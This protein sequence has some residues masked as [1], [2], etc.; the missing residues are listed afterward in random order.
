V[1]TLEMTLKI[2]AQGFVLHPGSYLRSAWN[3]VDAVIVLSALISVASNDDSLTIMRA[4]R[5]LRTLRPLRMISRLRGLQ[6]V[7]TALIRSLPAV[8]NVV[9]FGV[10][11]VG[12]FGI[13]GV[14]LFGGKFYSCNDTNVRLRGECIGTF[15]CDQTSIEC[16]IGT[17][18]TRLW[19]NAYLN[20]DN[21]GE[22]AK[23]LFVVATLDDWMRVTYLCMDAVDVDVQPRENNNP[24]MA[25]YVLGFVLLGSFFWINLLVGVIIDNYT[26]LVAELGEAGILTGEQQ[27]WMHALQLKEIQGL[28]QD[29]RNAPENPLR[30]F[31]FMTIAQTKFELFITSCIL[32]NVLIMATETGSQSEGYFEFVQGANKAFTS[33][34][35]L[36][37]LMKVTALSP[38][39]YI[40]DGWNLFDF[41]IVVVSL[42]DLF[43]S[44]N[45]FQG[46]TVFRIFRVGRLFKLIAGA[47]GLRTLFNT[48]L[49]S[50]PAI[51]NVG[52]LLF[53]LMFVYGVM[54]MNMF[55]TNTNFETHANFRDFGMS[56]LTLFRV[57]TGDSWSGVLAAAQNCDGHGGCDKSPW[58]SIYFLSFTVIGS[59][60][61]LNLIIAVIL[62]QFITAASSEGLLRTDNFFDVLS[63]KVILDRFLW[64]LK[65]KLKALANGADIKEMQERAAKKKQELVD[66]DILLGEKFGEMY[67]SVN[68]KKKSE[69]RKSKKAENG[70]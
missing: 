46:A 54:G 11:E 12:V 2:V 37:A 56:L 21:I 55:G 3:V 63:K 20:F 38:V 27:K 49:S 34:F 69:R 60:V 29:M 10:F 41:V 57:F 58:P 35:L 31:I 52:G 19:E 32:L 51:F 68:S 61:M 43:L 8:L 9:L 7:V 16:E 65:K 62:D 66:M 47:R 25:L 30:R 18:T 67:K 59:F 14:Q 70:H 48:L 1:F 4:L 6:L 23:A 13:L 36:E 53:L 45:G 26:Q 33:I 24:I 28:Q 64:A 44:Y 42:P 50:L 22:A 39:K 40:M 5:L 17:V 15:I